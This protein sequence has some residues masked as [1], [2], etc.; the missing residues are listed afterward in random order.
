MKRATGKAST[1]EKAVAGIML[2]PRSRGW[3]CG[4]NYLPFRFSQF[5]SNKLHTAGRLLSAD[6]ERVLDRKEKG[7]STY[8]S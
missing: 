4:R 2:T 6:A 5:L 1:R 8:P 3:T 7:V